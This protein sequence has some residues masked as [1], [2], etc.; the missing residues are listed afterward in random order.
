[1]KKI[2]L[3]N[4]LIF[5]FLY[6]ILEVFSGNLI[7]KN[8]LS[9]GYLKCNFEKDYEINLYTDDKIKVKFK[10]N[11]LGFRGEEIFP[12]QIHTIIMG[13]STTAQ[14]YLNEEDT[15]IKKLE[16]KFNSKDMKIKFVNAGIDGQSTFGHIWN[17]KNWIPKIK[18]IKPKYIIFYIGVNEYGDT[19]GFF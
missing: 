5:I 10:K 3:I 4:I 7:Y 16:N 8:K 9:C 1:M 13:G 12:D 15:W 2:L 19:R 14:R 17:L 11:S 6:L 18:K